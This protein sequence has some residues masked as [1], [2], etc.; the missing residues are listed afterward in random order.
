MKPLKLE[1]LTIELTQDCV[2]RCAYCSSLSGCLVRRPALTASTVREVVIEAVALG[3]KRLCVSGGE[4]FLHEHL[5]EVIEA[6]RESDLE[7]TLFFT[8]GVVRSHDGTPAPLSDPLLSKVSDCK[9]VRLV[10]NIQSLD[11]VI[12]DAIVGA[13][14][15]LATTLES[16]RAA[17][18]RGIPVECHMV[19]NRLNV[20]TLVATTRMLLAE[21]VSRISFLRM[22]PQGNAARNEGIRLDRRSDAVLEQAIAKLRPLAFEGGPLR[23][24]V[25]FSTHGGHLSQCKAG[26]SKLIVR[27]DGAVFP[28]EAF[29]ECGV[30][31]L[32]LG[33][34][35]EH[36][37]CDFLLAAR[38]SQTL[39][40]L[41]D[42][43]GHSEP[44]PA[45]LLYQKLG[46]REAI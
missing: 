29:K 41:R 37:L 7:Q 33:R 18:T 3:L 31:A 12:H 36:P 27:W 26:L 22:V 10:F 11:P 30:K 21:G 5:A 23:F 45:Q 9:G 44:C 19:P 4:P 42:R 2:N 43:V 38:K 32:V 16:L 20:D 34:V 24:G 1:E 46:Y 17:I 6:L 14:G 15:R 39:I 28:C 35:G 25:P 13:T 40:D 8:S